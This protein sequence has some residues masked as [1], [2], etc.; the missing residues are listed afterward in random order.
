MGDSSDEDD[1]SSFGL[2]LQQA[3]SL[4]R[5]AWDD[6]QRKRRELQQHGRMYSNS[7]ANAAAAATT[8]SGT[9]ITG[10]AGRVTGQSM[11]Y[12]NAIGSQEQGVEIDP[13]ATTGMLPQLGT[14]TSSFPYGDESVDTTNVMNVPA[15]TTTATIDT[16]GRQQLTAK[17]AVPWTAAGIALGAVGN[18]FRRHRR[19]TTSAEEKKEFEPY[20][21]GNRDASQPSQFSFVY[22]LKGQTPSL[23]DGSSLPSEDP[24]SKAVR[25][26]PTMSSWSSPAIHTAAVAPRDASSPATTRETAEEEEDSDDRDARE[27]LKEVAQLSDFVKRYEQQK[28]RQSQPIVE[29][30]QSDAL[31]DSVSTGVSGLSSILKSG[32]VEQNVQAEPAG[33][34]YPYDVAFSATDSDRGDDSDGEEGSVRLG[35]SRYAVQKPPA[36]LLSYKAERPAINDSSDEDIDHPYKSRGSDVAP[37]EDEMADTV[38]RDTLDEGRVLSS[39][40]SNRAMLDDA[41]VDKETRRTGEMGGGKS[42]TWNPAQ[43]TP[44]VRT[45]NKEFAT[46]V[47]MFEERPKT[48]VTPPD[49][50]WQ[51]NY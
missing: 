22:P 25:A 8:G 13:T 14:T 5:E 1:V 16:T 26:S 24:S 41:A 11:M 40:R 44:R 34:K 21:D 42:R 46:K 4:D 47:T 28:S 18:R 30:S 33:S 20:G 17:D 51:F 10:T 31:D 7:N 9:T 27:M 43:I 32:S 3:A 19:D 15:G 6:F 45:T 48:A 23:M 12:Y 38:E 37:A 49:E 2:E 35:I 50:S 36:P 29:S 39:L